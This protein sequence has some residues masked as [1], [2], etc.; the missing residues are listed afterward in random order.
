MPD[1]S[2]PARFPFGWRGAEYTRRL[3]EARRAE[4][5]RRSS[6]A[7]PTTETGQFESWKYA[8]KTSNLVPGPSIRYIPPLKTDV[9]INGQTFSRVGLDPNTGTMLY[10][11]L[12]KIA[13]VDPRTNKIL[14]IVDEDFFR[15]FSRPYIYT[16]PAIPTSPVSTIPLSPEEIGKRVGP[17]TIPSCRNC[18]VAIPSTVPTLS[19]PPTI[20]PRPERVLPSTPPVQK[21]QMRNQM[22]KRGSGI[23][24][25]RARRQGPPLVQPRFPADGGDGD[26]RKAL[27][28][29]AFLEQQKRLK[30]RAEEDRKRREREIRPGI[31]FRSVPD[32]P[33]Q[34]V[35][36][37]NT[38]YDQALWEATKGSAPPAGGWD[39]IQMAPLPLTKPTQPTLY[40]P[41]TGKRYPIG[42]VVVPAPE[43]APKAPVAPSPPPA[44]PSVP[45]VAETPTPPGPPATYEEVRDQQKIEALDALVAD[46]QSRYG[47]P[48]GAFEPP[49]VK[50]F[51]DTAA[52][53]GLGDMARYMLT[54]DQRA[55]IGLKGVT[56][57]NSSLVLLGAAAFGLYLFTSWRNR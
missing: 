54:P 46:F 3:Q 32:K 37:R 19:T 30:Q 49:M 29:Q 2:V 22:R 11:R 55:A 10:R 42:P 4:Q 38:A 27:Q 15:T 56:I 43:S 24:K 1:Q 40:D 50:E 7:I 5:Q 35:A 13:M 23:K 21:R 41:S 45:P 53:L 12:D 34:P 18:P 57:D 44:V 52:S 51:F 47:R 14:E 25:M 39:A 36:P 16:N 6:A 9:T 26:I 31:L 20:V 48:L 28:R 17:Q 33:G 8:P